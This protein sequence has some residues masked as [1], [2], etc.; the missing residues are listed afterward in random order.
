MEDFIEPDAKEMGRGF[1]L[2]GDDEPIK[3]ENA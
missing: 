1:I 2:E 3:E